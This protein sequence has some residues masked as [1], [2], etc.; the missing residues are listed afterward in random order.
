MT[1]SEAT[2]S[3]L[4]HCSFERRLSVHTMA[5][6]EADLR[7]FRKWLPLG[8]VF[9]DI[10]EEDLKA[11]LE[12]MVVSRGSSV[13]TVRRRLACLRSFYRYGREARWPFDPFGTWRPKLPRSRRLPRSL[14]RTEVVSLIVK[15]QTIRRMDRDFRPAMLLMIATGLR[16]GE[17][18]G[19]KVE[20]VSPDCSEIRIRGKGARD[21]VV[22]VTDDTLKNEL[23]A[24]VE[25]RR[26]KAG[27]LA[28]LWINRLGR[29]MRPQS[30]RC[31]LRRAAECAGVR[32][33]ITPHMLRHTAATLLIET[34]VDIRFVQRLLGHSSIA[35][36]EIYTH[37]TDEAL[38][39][40]LR[41]ADVLAGFGNTRDALL[42]AA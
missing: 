19:I 38:R 24:I 17:L 16:V 20:D 7:D 37:V 10:A 15:G 23:A 39:T 5:A 30:I 8:K 22:Y 25:Q 13:A 31:R 40:T 1:F 42:N 4:Q 26:V 34:G 29:P 21:R 6:Y 11:Y 18:C 12:H 41:K 14:A 35:T 33:R 32:R 2:R 3:F 9:E 36:T 28:G 27:D